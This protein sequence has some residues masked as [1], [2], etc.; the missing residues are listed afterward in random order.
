MYSQTL[1]GDDPFQAIIYISIDKNI[2]QCL[3]FW[4][5]MYGTSVHYLLVRYMQDGVIHNNAWFYRVGSQGDY[6]HLSRMPITPDYAL[7][8]VCLYY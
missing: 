3:E 5:Y 2:T 4:Y 7:E 1:Y 8:E 6:W